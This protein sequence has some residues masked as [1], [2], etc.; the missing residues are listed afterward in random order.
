LGK[1]YHEK[2]RS[3]KYLVIIIICF[4]FISCKTVEQKIKD[5]SYTEEW[6]LLDEQ[7][8]QVYQTKN[9]KKYIII[10]N[11][12]QNKLIRYYL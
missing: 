8:Y 4:F 9:S 3:M 6:Y 7:I 11:N 5:Y 12:K 1:S 2:N 10:L